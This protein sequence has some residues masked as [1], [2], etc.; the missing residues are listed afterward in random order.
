MNNVVA[1]DLQKL[2]KNVKH[3]FSRSQSAVM[4]ILFSNE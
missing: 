4:P 1:S 2:K 3:W